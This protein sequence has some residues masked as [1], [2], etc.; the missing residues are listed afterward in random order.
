MRKRILISCLLVLMVLIIIF[1]FLYLYNLNKKSNII[2]ENSVSEVNK[3]EKINE[4]NNPI[5]PNGFKKVETESASWKLENSVPK[6]WNNGLIIE[7]EIGNQFVWVPVDSVEN[8]NSLIYRNPNSKTSYGLS[9]GDELSQLQKYSG[10]YVARYEAGVPK[11]MQ[12]NLKNISEQTNDIVGIPVSKKGI[13]PWNYISKEN[14]EKSADN[15]YSNEYVSSGLL[16]AKQW[17]HI[18][19]WLQKCGYE[20]DD[21][22]KYGNFS[23]VNFTFTGLY[24][25]DIGKTYT[26]GENKNKA[27]INMILATGITDRN[28]T[29]NIYDFYGN[30]E[31]S[32]V[33][34]IAYGGYYDNS[35]IS[36][37][38]THAWANSKV[39]F[40]VVLNLK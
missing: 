10:F 1:L 35:S 38:S 21:P 33:G 4:Y 37:S 12:N 9:N 20:V 40:R 29:N 22:N 16:R 25:D 17:V 31:E 24:S 6:G 14:V 27:T 30:V 11:E 13:I 7:D 2:N 15:M 5:V 8:Y 23:N 3:I 18:N 26:Y 28:K 39:G 34:Y 32:T 19:S 36:E